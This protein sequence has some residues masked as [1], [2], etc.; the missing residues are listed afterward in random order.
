MLAPYL[1]TGN[2]IYLGFEQ[3]MARYELKNNGAVSAKLS[4]QLH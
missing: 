3:I 2:T 1:V 4:V